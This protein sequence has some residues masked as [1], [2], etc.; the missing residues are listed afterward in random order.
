M[1]LWNVLLSKVQQNLCYCK[2]YLIS[3]SNEDDSLLRKHLTRILLD[4]LKT[5]AVIWSLTLIDVIRL[6]SINPDFIMSI[7]VLDPKAYDVFTGLFDPLIEEYYADFRT[8]DV[9]S[10]LDWDN[11]KKLNNPYP[12][13]KHVILIRFR[14]VKSIKN[15]YHLILPWIKFAIVS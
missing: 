5:R 6:A 12:R 15:Y 8:D 10:D 3:F 14:C 9:H 1:F 11:L 4:E 13:K 7:H 2:T